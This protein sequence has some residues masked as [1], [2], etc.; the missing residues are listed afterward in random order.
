MDRTGEGK[1]ALC[2]II[3]ELTEITEVE[4]DDDRCVSGKKIVG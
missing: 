3:P 2:E 1:I 4:R